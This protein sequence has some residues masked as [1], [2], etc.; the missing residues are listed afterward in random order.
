ML[1]RETI[2]AVALLLERFDFGEAPGR[3]RVIDV[4]LGAVAAPAWRQLHLHHVD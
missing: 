3:V 2:G 1:Q 4:I